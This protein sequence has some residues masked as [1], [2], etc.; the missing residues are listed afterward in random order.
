MLPGAID[1]AEGRLY[2]ELDLLIT[3]VTDT[4]GSFSIQNRNFALPT[5]IGTFLVVEELS[6]ITP[7]GVSANTGTRNPLVPTSKQ[8]ID[9]VY[10]SAV[11]ANG[12]PEFYARVSDTQ[13]IV[14]PAPDMSY[15]A[16]VI[17]T[18]RPLPLTAA[19]SSTF[20]TQI[21]PELF[22]VASMVFVSGYMRDFGAQTDNPQMSEVLGI[23][24]RQIIAMGQH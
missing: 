3:R 20:L 22:I 9:A 4:S 21:L 11:T 13:I 6:A 16:E 8:F 7:S 23:T 14:G 2:R 24:V 10:P 1:Y 18:Q 15:V 12:V 19:N 5:S 17:G